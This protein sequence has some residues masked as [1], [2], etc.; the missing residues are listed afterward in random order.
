M[1]LALHDKTVLVTGSSSGIGKETAKVFAQEGA[2][3]IIHYNQNKTAAEKLQKAIGKEHFVVQANLEKEEE[4]LKMFA[5]IKEKVRIIDILVCNA[6]IWPED[7]TEIKDMSYARWKKT[8]TV[9]LDSVFFCCRSFIK[10]LYD[11]DNETGN[12]VIVGSTAATFGEA[13]HADYAAAKAAITYGLTKSLKNEI[14]IAARH[15]RVN[16]V[17]PG[18]TVTPMNEKFLDDEGGIKHALKTVPLKKLG[19]VEDIASII[20]VLAS[21]KVS[22]HISGEIL[23]IAGGMEGRALHLADEIEFKKAFKR[24]KKKE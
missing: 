10:Q 11:S 19:E 8:I 13:G 21:D 12:I 23:S 17:C 3:V 6:G 15:G 22:G 4:V 16:T 24:K 20:T 14:V 9:D 1:D 5:T 18:W 2:R 7:Y